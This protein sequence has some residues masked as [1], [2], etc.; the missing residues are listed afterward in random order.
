[1]VRVCALVFTDGGL[2]LAGLRTV[3]LLLGAM[4]SVTVAAMSLVLNRIKHS[5]QPRQVPA[6]V[7]PKPS[8]PPRLRGEGVTITALISAGVF[9]VAIWVPPKDS[10]PLQDLTPQPVLSP[11]A[12]PSASAIGPGAGIY[13]EYASGSSGMGCTAG[14]LVRTSTGQPGFLT[15]GHCNRPGNP[16]RVTMN[17]GGILP[18]AMLGRFSRTINE[19]SGDDQHDI[20]LIMLDGES[21]PQTSAIAASLPVSGVATDLWVGQ[22]LCKYGMTTGHEECGQVLDITG[23]KVV[24]AAAGQCGDSGG[25][26]YAVQSDGTASAVGIDIRG[27][28]PLNPR[29]GCSAPAKFSVAELVQPW[30]KTW[31]LTV[32]TNEAAE[33]R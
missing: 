26:V 5:G 28:N 14:F 1:M 32:V 20:G 18:Y 21:V 25:P 4:A 2:H 15:A 22:Q 8:R 3:L 29:A 16:S 17:L 12:L 33:P 31:N 7:L 23:S 10:D 13:V 9:V 19:G 11:I 6:S 24:F 27:G 30:L